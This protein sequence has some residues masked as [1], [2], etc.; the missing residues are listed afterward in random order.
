[1]YSFSFVVGMVGLVSLQGARETLGGYASSLFVCGGVKTVSSCAT[2][3]IP[4]LFLQSR[5]A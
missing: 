3:Q 2:S 5:R 4:S 1:M